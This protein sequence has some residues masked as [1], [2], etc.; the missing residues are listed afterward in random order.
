MPV[1]LKWWGERWLKLTKF[2][3]N[4][5]LPWPTRIRH[6]PIGWA[7][8][9]LKTSPTARDLKPKLVSL[10]APTGLFFVSTM[11]WRPTDRGE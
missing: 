8:W 4:F 5:F 11:L 10:Q 2:K 1:S 7:K 9:P 6:S 3:P